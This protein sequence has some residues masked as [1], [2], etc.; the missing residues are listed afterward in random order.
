MKALVASRFGEPA[1][2]LELKALPDPQPPGAGEVLIRVT[3]RQ[4]HPATSP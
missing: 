3:K 4:L 1:K 2:V